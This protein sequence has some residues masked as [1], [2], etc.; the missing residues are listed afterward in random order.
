[1]IYSVDSPVHPLNNQFLVD[2]HLIGSKTNP[3]SHTVVKFTGSGQIWHHN[4]Y[5]AAN[6]RTNPLKGLCHDIWCHFKYLKMSLNQWKPKNNYSV[7]LRETMLQP[8]DRLLSLIVTDGKDGDGLQ[9]EKVGQLFHVLTLNWFSCWH[10]IYLKSFRKKIIA[11]LLVFKEVYYPQEK[12]IWNCICEVLTRKQ[13]KYRDIA[14]LSIQ[15]TVQGILT[16]SDVLLAPT[17]KNSLA[18]HKN[19]VDF[20]WIA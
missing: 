4:F 17:K 14:S 15:N 11:D 16:T 3:N 2:R 19:K 6:W 9:L 1:M 5:T 13:Q 12:A 18:I 8:W 10:R 7:C 20:L